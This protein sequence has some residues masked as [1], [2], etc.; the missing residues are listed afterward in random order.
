MQSAVKIA[1]IIIASALIVGCKKKD[2]T[3]VAPVITFM[4]AG[5]SED[6][7]YSIVRFE[8]YDGDG[9]LG[10]R[11]DENTGDQEF[12]LYVDY[13]EKINGAWVLKSPVITY[14]TSEAKFDTTE[15]HLRVPFVENDAQQALEGETVVNLFY[16][17]NADT[18]RY[19]LR[20]QDRAL[21]MSNRIT[22]SELVIN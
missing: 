16:N 20:M 13:Y 5:L 18:F 3:P 12:N 7:S 19:E 1:I 6:N 17:F 10:L 11:Q 22:T 15:L 2:P 8:F 4:D 9:D 14:N 21:Q